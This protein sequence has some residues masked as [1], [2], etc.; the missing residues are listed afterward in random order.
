MKRAAQIARDDKT[1]SQGELAQVRRD[2]DEEIAKTR[3]QQGQLERMQALLESLEHTKGDLVRRL[4]G[5]NTEKMS[6]EQEKQL[7]LND[8]QTYKRELLLKEQE[9]ND[10]RRSVEQ[11]DAS[12]DEL[13]SELDAKTEELAA[14]RSQL[15]KQ[16]REFSNVQH[17]ISSIAGKED[18]I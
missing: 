2:L 7:L 15:D 14:A 17:Q 16:A 9:L 5:V 11:L 13:Q 3:T 1:K 12:K 6:E 10:L 4:Q 8:V 18:T